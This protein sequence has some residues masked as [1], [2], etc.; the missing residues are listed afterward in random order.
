MPPRL[1][2][3]TGEEKDVEDIILELK[4]RGMAGKVLVF[5][6]LDN[7][8]FFSM[9]KT[10]GTSLPR[11]DKSDGI[12]HIPGRLIVASGYAL[13]LM[14]DNVMK[15]SRA[16]EPS[17]TVIITPMP[18]FWTLAVTHTR[19]ARDQGGAGQAAQGSQ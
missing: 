12:F 14:L 8:T 4:G 18:R 13:E 16:V 17:M 7:G 3:P 1:D 19:R 15:I 9:N 5:H 10:G 11:R 6:C 2:G